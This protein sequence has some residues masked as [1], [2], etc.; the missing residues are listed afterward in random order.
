MGVVLMRNLMIRWRAGRGSGHLD[1][2]E[3]GVQNAEGN[4]D[5]LLLR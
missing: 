3:F 4:K 5:I 2:A 1:N